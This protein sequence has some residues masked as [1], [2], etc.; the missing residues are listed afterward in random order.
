VVV[1]VDSLF[2][3]KA[4]RGLISG[5]IEI[6]FSLFSLEGFSL[7]GPVY[8]KLLSV[9]TF[10]HPTP[11]RHVAARHIYLAPGPRPVFH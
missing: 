11:S 8:G 7:G 1:G 6:V 9:T 2:P 10:Q 5:Q 3:E 4:R